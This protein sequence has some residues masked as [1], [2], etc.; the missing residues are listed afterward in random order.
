M[1]LIILF[2][3]FFTPNQDT[4]KLNNCYE[5]AYDSYPNAYAKNYYRS[6]TN[7]KLKNL[8]VNY[9]PQ[10]SF[11]GQATYQSDVPVINIS[12]PQ[13]KPPE[14]SKDRYQ[15]FM[16]LKQLIYDGGTTSS[17][18]DVEEK[19]LSTDNQKIEVE[20]YALRQRVN[21]LYF[22]ALLIQEKKNVT[23]NLYDDIKSRITEMES[24]VENGTIQKVIYIYCRHN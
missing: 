12:I 16:D 24:R 18:K 14:L 2:L 19:Q 9:Y 10:I 22:S 15:I 6:N 7:L 11:K 13:F 1:N 17:L 5:K 23:Q 3:M 21:D 20:L 8:D 4:L